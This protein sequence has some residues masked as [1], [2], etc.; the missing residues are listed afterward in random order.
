MATT[1][2]P[3]QVKLLPRTLDAALL[4]LEVV[5]AKLGRTLDA[6][7]SVRHEM[8]IA[9]EALAGA[10]QELAGTT[11]ALASTRQQLAAAQQA[12]AEKSMEARALLRQVEEGAATR[13]TNAG[14]A[15]TTPDILIKAYR[16][17]AKGVPQAAIASQLGLTPSIVYQFLLGTYGSKAAKRAYS[18]LTAA[19]LSPLAWNFPRP[20]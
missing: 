4:R 20:P 15:H 5:R 3:E 18:E 12:L 8:A 9:N 13:W 19:G 7:A 1:P 14:R 10:R 16:M 2:K 17:A 11:E 6:L